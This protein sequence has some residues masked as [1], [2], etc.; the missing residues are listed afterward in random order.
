MG[1][2]QIH[3]RCTTMG[4]P[5]IFPYVAEFFPKEQYSMLIV[6]GCLQCLKFANLM[7]KKQYP[8]AEII[9]LHNHLT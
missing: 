6:M 2:S 5:S 9:I 3:F 1:A 4:T 7:D 8:I